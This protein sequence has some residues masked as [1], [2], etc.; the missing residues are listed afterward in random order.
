MGMFDTIRTSHEILGNP[1][2]LSLQTKDLA[3]M[4]ANY[5]ISPAC[6]LYLI[7]CDGVADLHIKPTEERKNRLDMFEWKLNGRRGHLRPVDYSGQI[8]VVGKWSPDVWP[9]AQLYFGNGYLL[10]WIDTSERTGPGTL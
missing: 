3:C 10:G 9:K 1:S 4:M 7:D 6:E 8:N 2:D 5:W